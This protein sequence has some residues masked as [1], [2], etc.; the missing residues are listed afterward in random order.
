MCRLCLSKYVNWY[1]GIKTSQQHLMFYPWTDHTYNQTY[2]KTDPIYQIRDQKYYKCYKCGN[3]IT[4]DQI[5]LWYDDPRALHTKT[6]IYNQEFDINK[7]QTEIAQ[8]R[9][10]LMQLQT[11]PNAIV[12]KPSQYLDALLDITPIKNFLNGTDLPALTRYLSQTRTS[13]DYGPVPLISMIDDFLRNDSRMYISTLQRYIPIMDHLVS[14]HCF[15]DIQ[16]IVERLKNNKIQK[17]IS[18][19]VCQECLEEADSCE[20]CDAPII[21]K[22]YAFPTI[23]ADDEYICQKCIDNGRYDVCTECGRADEIADMVNTEEGSYCSECG[24]KLNNVEAWRSKIEE[25]ANLNDLPFNAWFNPDNPEE[26]NDPEND[27][28][29]IPYIPKMA[30]QNEDRDVYDFLMSKGFPKRLPDGSMVKEKILITPESYIQGYCQVGKR[31]WKIGRLLDRLRRKELKSIDPN[32]DVDGKLRQETNTEYDTLM[33]NFESAS[34]RQLK[35]TDDLMVVISQNP[36]DIAAMSTQQ[37]WDSCM[38]LGVGSYYNNVFDEIA[39]GGLIA[40]LIREDDRDIEEAL[41]RVL[42]RRYSGR[43]GKNVAM[44]SDEVYGLHGSQADDFRNFV[45]SWLEMKQGR[46]IPDNDKTEVYRIRGM[47]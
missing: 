14:S 41:G 22:E 23:W 2:E 8:F 15:I 29:Y 42:I 26:T 25:S 6:Y 32:I 13:Y 5:G 17:P 38:T 35:K 36:F 40:Y 3:I 18:V 39:E 19:P 9:V 30:L 21:N 11:D 47:N 1:N 44:A 16:N 31:V 7:I 46:K 12:E 33:H 24:E 20:G 28:I 43:G 34:T 45:Q 37:G 4:E 10:R 27:R